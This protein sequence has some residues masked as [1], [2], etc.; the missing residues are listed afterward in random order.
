MK[1]ATQYR[2]VLRSSGSHLSWEQKPVLKVLKIVAVNSFIAWRIFERREIQQS[3]FEV[4][5]SDTY[6]KSL[7]KVS[8]T[9]DFMFDAALDLLLRGRSDQH[10]T[11]EMEFSITF[12][13]RGQRESIHLASNRKRSQI[14][15]LN[16]PKGRRRNGMCLVTL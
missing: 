10:S 14:E 11:S 1:G 12:P 2:A 3:Q 6:R 8:S 4:K 15:F 16:S 9:A 13:D 7:N 5:C